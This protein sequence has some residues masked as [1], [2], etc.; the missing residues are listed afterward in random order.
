[1]GNFGNFIKTQGI[2]YAQGVKSDTKDF[3]KF[4]QQNCMS[5]RS[6]FYIWDSCASHKLAQGTFAVGHRKYKKIVNN[7]G[8]GTPHGYT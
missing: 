3:F 1:M 6:Q 7:V 2:V 5:L 4:L 8:V